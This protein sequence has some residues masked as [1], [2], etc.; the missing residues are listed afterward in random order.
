MRLCF[1]RPKV[2][3]NDKDL[4]RAILIAGEQILDGLQQVAIATQAVA[5]ALQAL[6]P[7]KADTLS[8]ILIPNKGA[9][10]FA[11]TEAPLTVNVGVTGTTTVVETAKGV[12]V[13]VVGPIVYASDNP[14]VATYAPD[15]TWAAVGIGTCNMSQLDQGNGLTDS[16]PLTVQ[17]APPPVADTLIGTLVPKVA[18]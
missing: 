3:E 5:S 6:A 12:Q 10:M 9:S 14:A 17:A 1:W 2:S 8:A 4:A 13:P 7:P 15:G 16:T 18:R 11:K